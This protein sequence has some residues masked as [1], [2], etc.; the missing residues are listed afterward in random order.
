MKKKRIMTAEKLSLIEYF[1]QTG[2]Y[3]KYKISILGPSGIFNIINRT[4][5]IDDQYYNIVFTHLVVDEEPA[6]S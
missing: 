3:Y 4:P 5:E 6:Q 2:S 1:S